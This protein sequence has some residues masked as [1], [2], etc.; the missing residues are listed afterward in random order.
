MEVNFLSKINPGSNRHE[1]ND[2]KTTAPDTQD[3]DIP[4]PKKLEKGKLQCPACNAIFDS[5][6]A[7]ISHA[8]S[9]HQEH[10]EEI[11]E[12]PSM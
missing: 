1:D 6:E 8:L 5:R 4:E 11:I 10:P 3:W 12:K 7:Y 2:L 9:R